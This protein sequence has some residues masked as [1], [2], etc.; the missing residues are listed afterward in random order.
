[1]NHQFL[2]IKKYAITFCIL[3]QSLFFASPSNGQLLI[4]HIRVESSKNPIGIDVK[5]PSISWQLQS[6]DMQR[7]Q[8]QLAYQIEVKDQQGVIVWN[9][10]KVNSGN[11][12]GIIYA[13]AAL[14]ASNKYQLNVTV[15]DL[16]GR[17]SKATSWFE[18]GLMNPNISAWEGATWIG[19][20]NDDLV[21]YS[22]YLPLFVLNCDLTIA[23]GSSKASIILG[24]NDPRL[25]D[26]SKNILG[27]ASAKNE[28]YL[29]VE[30]DIDTVNGSDTGLAKLH[31]YRVGYTANDQAKRP[32][33][34]FAIKQSLINQSNKN[35]QHHI[36]IRDQYGELFVVID[37]DPAQFIDLSKE[38]AG[39]PLFTST[40]QGASVNL[41][42][43]GKGH[44]YIS[45]GML[46][47]LGFSVDKGQ[48][49][50]FQ[51][52]RV[53]NLRSPSNILF[54]EDLSKSNYNGIFK[55]A[56]LENP[57]D[58][59]INQQ[60]YILNGKNK[61]VFVV[62]DPSRNAMPMLRTKFTVATQK[63]KDAKLYITARG[64][65]EVFLNGKRVGNDHF[66]PGLTQ[67]NLTH[68]YQ[69]Y[70]VTNMVSAGQN[71]LGAMLGEGWWSGLLSFGAIWNHFGDRQSLLAKLV[72]TYADGTKKLITTNEKDWKYFNNGPIVYSSLDMGEVYDATKE[73]AIKNWSTANYDDRKWKSAVQVS[74]DGTVYKEGS[75]NFMGE[76]EKINW[77]Q[78]SLIGQIGENAGVYKVLNAKSVKQI[79]KGIY[80]YNMGQ[81]FV[82][83]PKINIK[84]GRAGQQITIRVSEVLYPNLKE[85]KNNVGQLMTE[86]YRAALSQDLYTTKDG[87]QVIQPRFTSHG[88]QYI[89]ISGLDQ[90]LPLN[91]VEGLCISSIKNLTA[92]YQTSN[93]KVNQLWSN[94]VWSNVD[95]FLS[96]PTDCPQRNERMGWSGDI[97]VFSRTATYISNS[98]QF[99]KRHMMAMRDVQNEKGKFADISPV[100]GGFGGLLW[101]SA[102][103]TVP[104]EVY[105]QYNNLGLLQEH[106]PAMVKYI[107]YLD[108]AINKETGF[109]MDKQLGDWLG[110]QNNQLGNDY[111]VTAYH[112]YD[113]GIMQRVATLLGK[114]TDAD[115]F[116]NMYEERKTF[117]NKTF[118]NADKK[119]M[120]LIGGG[121]FGAPAGKAIWKL[122]DIQSAYAV[123]LALNAFS[124]E[125]IPFMAENLRAAV[126]R[127]NLGDDNM[128]RPKYSL[129][130]GFIGT[131][132]ISK[133]LSD[134]GYSKLAYQL[135]QNDQYPSWL[136]AVDQGATT[137]WERL[138]GYTTE[139]G[140]GGNNSMN[141]FNH[142]SFGAV[143]Q[144]MINYSLGIQRDEP[145]FKK[146]ILQPAP[147]Q[148]GKMTWAKG[149]YVSEYGRINSAWKIANQQLTYTATVPVNTSATLYLPTKD[150]A[151]VTESGKS[152][153]GAKGIRFLE[154]KNGKALY[155]LQSGNYVFTSKYY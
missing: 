44:D 2:L 106:Y 114:Q 99:L 49:A 75:V 5:T 101:G 30:L 53:N 84:N 7:G 123:G 47:D 117:F 62:A 64:I 56:L 126:E 71:A 42:P 13:G 154:Y 105:Q 139:N 82:G 137:I 85:Y 95:N 88:Y 78:I 80:V 33:K 128:L 1:M 20:S 58:F 96:I 69:T 142:Y 132:W 43:M 50:Q 40:R 90:A 146:F 73:S 16:N 67:Y 148:S 109:C 144:W 91:A 87:D 121:G 143:G 133:A 155:E 45:F 55:K 108:A 83:V 120:G 59:H 25:M 21:L 131:A 93:Q 94:L 81:N 140:F 150:P 41:N 151:S 112:V 38:S 77:D 76:K 12:L 66:N 14:K 11:A 111:L 98:N 135:L 153:V 118:V 8:G 29:K 18:M 65:Y 35:A 124:A 110:P 48:E 4:E 63:I 116:Q 46:C 130:T 52:L 149:Y 27:I 17:I 136:Y 127:E 36:S 72:I 26:Q 15:W 97:S 100:G 89:E 113:L 34:T 141:S 102:G 32:I 104:W 138:N 86:N 103:I 54:Q 122:A 125:N 129:M 19:G 119:A 70:D 9:S 74:L 145:G 39:S 37:N 79:A 3:A 31:F 10:G 107:N 22:K 152:I 147:D 23:R 57:A 24:A 68:M 28:N 134:H 115:R 6:S 60:S 92:D 51:N 61:T